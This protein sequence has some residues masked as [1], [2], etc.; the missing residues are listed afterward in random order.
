MKKSNHITDLD[1]IELSSGWNYNSKLVTGK[2]VNVNNHVYRVID[3]VDPTNTGLGYK[4]YERYDN[5]KSR[6]LHY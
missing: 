6:M 3:K 1:T 5:D 4:L 2:N